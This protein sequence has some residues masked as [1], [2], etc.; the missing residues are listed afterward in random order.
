MTRRITRRRALAELV[1]GAGLLATGCAGESSIRPDAGGCTLHTTY[2]DPRGTGTLVVAP[3]EPLRPRTELGP[4]A[5]RVAVL[6][7]IAHL[8][9]AHVLDAQSPARVTFLDRLGVPFESTFR[10]QETLTTQV[11]AGALHATAALGPD[12]VIQGAT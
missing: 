11:L 8:T 6:A 9:D 1:A 4:P 7:T 3:G 2:R 10:P 5:R 12:A